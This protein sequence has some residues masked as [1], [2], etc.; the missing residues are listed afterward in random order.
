MT[1]SVEIPDEVVEKALSGYC[2]VPTYGTYRGQFDAMRAA[3]VAARPYLMPSRE[4]ITGE[5]VDD[6][7]REAWPK[8]SEWDQR[9]QTVFRRTAR[10]ALELP[11]PVLPPREAIEQAIDPEPEHQDH[12]DPWVLWLRRSTSRRAKADAVL[13]LL[14]GDESGR[15]GSEFICSDSPDGRHNTVS[16]LGGNDEPLGYNHCGYC[17][18]R[19]DW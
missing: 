5:E 10:R 12:D 3:L 13:A 2:L 14:N 11:L 15:G 9:T 17:G 16:A 6:F 8:F 18:T 4:A 7:C 1:R 19:L